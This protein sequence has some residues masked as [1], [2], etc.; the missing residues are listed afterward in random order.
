ME[1]RWPFYLETSLKI[2]IF[3]Y[4]DVLQPSIKNYT[5][6]PTKNSGEQN[7]DDFQNIL[8]KFA[9]DNQQKPFSFIANV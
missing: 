1:T 2:Y 7:G 8:L 5:K 9:L 3:K 4:L 6:N